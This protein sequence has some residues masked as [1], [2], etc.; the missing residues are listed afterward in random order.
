MEQLQVTQ[1]LQ[2]Y[3]IDQF[4]KPQPNNRTDEYGGSL[5]NR[6]RLALEIVEAVTD[7]IGSE[8]VGI[9]YSVTRLD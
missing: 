7:E 4:I 9:R 2:G 6:C 1:Q 3:I 5:E 8:R